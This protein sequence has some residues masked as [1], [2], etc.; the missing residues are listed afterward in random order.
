MVLLGGSGRG[1]GSDRGS[2]LRWWVDRFS[3]SWFLSRVLSTP[4]SRSYGLQWFSFPRWSSRLPESFLTAPPPESSRSRSFRVHPRLLQ[5]SFQSSRP[6]PLFGDGAQTSDPPVTTG[7]TPV[8]SHVYGPVSLVSLHPPSSGPVPPSL[9]T[10]S[11][12]EKNDLVVSVF[13]IV[14]SSLP[15]VSSRPP[16]DSTG[17]H[18][19]TQNVNNRTSHPGWYSRCTRTHSTGTRLSWYSCACWG[20]TSRVE[21]RSCHSNGLRCGSDHSGVFDMSGSSLHPGSIPDPVKVPPPTLL[22]VFLRRDSSESN[23]KLFVGDQVV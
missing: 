3:R 8:V 6:V 13:L 5:S 18:G 20:R 1:G 22:P 15:G 16:S 14:A 17:G 7:T 9:P 4:T 23:S 11:H 12:S 10:P 21:D 19:G 2:N